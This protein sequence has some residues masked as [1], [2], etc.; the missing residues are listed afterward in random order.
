MSTPLE[1]MPKSNRSVSWNVLGSDQS[2][3]PP[4]GSEA[5]YVHTDPVPPSA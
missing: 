5:R 2:M 1:E 3:P 4:A